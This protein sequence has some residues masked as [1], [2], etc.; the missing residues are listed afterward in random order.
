MFMPP[1]RF[2]RFPHLSG[3]EKA[4]AFQA[5]RMRSEEIARGM[6]SKP[7]PMRRPS[8]FARLKARAA[9]VTWDSWG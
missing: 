8:L 5:A 7:A 1:P 3:R 2:D 4:R 9:R 6:I